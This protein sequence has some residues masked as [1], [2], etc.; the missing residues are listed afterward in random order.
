MLIA[1]LAGKRLSMCVYKL[2]CAS[3]VL[4]QSES[5]CD[6]SRYGF[7]SRY[8]IS[9]FPLEFCDSRMCLVGLGSVTVILLWRPELVRSWAERRPHALL[10]LTFDIT[11]VCVQFII[12]STETQL[13]KNTEEMLNH[14]EKPR[15]NLLV[16]P[17]IWTKI[18]S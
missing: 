15:F 16:R 7:R 11:F 18:R 13:R 3:Y 14:M 2:A 6:A 8:L 17:C 12:M 4:D 1:A 5:Y 10:F 9:H